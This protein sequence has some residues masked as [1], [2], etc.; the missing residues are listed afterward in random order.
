LNTEYRVQS[1]KFLFLH[2]AGLSDPTSAL[3]WV[4]NP[5]PFDLL[6]SELNF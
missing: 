4:G 1:T 5:R 3:A 2:I 6:A